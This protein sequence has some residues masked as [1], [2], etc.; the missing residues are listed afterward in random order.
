[1]VLL[2]LSE[3]FFYVKLH[4]ESFKTLAILFVHSFYIVQMGV[5]Q[6]LS[7][8]LVLNLIIKPIID[9]LPIVGS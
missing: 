4:Q 9:N 3:A 2:F 7:L 6:F 8:D 5:G 1:M